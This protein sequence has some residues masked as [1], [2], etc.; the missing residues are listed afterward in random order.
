MLVTPDEYITLGIDKLCHVKT[1]VGEIVCQLGVDESEVDFF[2]LVKEAVISCGST[3]VIVEI[4]SECCVEEQSVMIQ[5]LVFVSRS[6]PR[7]DGREIE[8]DW[9]MQLLAQV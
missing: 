7:E 8:E 1:D 2:T 9:L 5:L 6:F 4:H 3:V